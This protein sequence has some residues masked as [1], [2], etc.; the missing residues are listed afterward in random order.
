MTV[1]LLEHGGLDLLLRTDSAF[2][3]TPIH[4]ALYA[5][6]E[7]L[8]RSLVEKLCSGSGDS[9]EVSERLGHA[10]QDVLR[11]MD[12]PLSLFRVLLSLFPAVALSSSALCC[13]G[14]AG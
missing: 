14:L 9:S 12:A 4:Y 8:A 5:G 6:N 10:K 11:H 2:D 13:Q 1:V 7:V 3:W